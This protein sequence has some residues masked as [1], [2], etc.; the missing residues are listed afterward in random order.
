MRRRYQRA[1]SIP[2]H[3][4]PPIKHW[5]AFPS[6]KRSPSLGTRSSSPSDR[7]HMPPTRG[8]PSPKRQ[9]RS[10]VRSSRDGRRDRQAPRRVTVES[11][12]PVP[13]RSLERDPK[14]RRISPN[15]KPALSPSLHKSPSSSVSSPAAERSPSDKRVK[16]DTRENKDPVSDKHDKNK[17]SPQVQKRNSKNDGRRNY[18]ELSS[19]RARDSEKGYKAD[20]MNQEA[21]KL[22][23]EERHNQSHSLDSGSEESDHTRKHKRKDATPGDD[24]S[25]DSYAEDRKEAKRRR[26]EEKKLKK[27]EKRKRREERRRKKDIR[28]SEKLKLKTL[29]NVSPSSDLDKSHDSHDESTLSDQK[30]LEIELRE[31]ALESLRAKKGAGR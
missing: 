6:R 7:I 23:K 2:R 13:A 25:H 14:G 3:K 21:V 16:E 11:R 10:P 4:S 18:P 15:G 8:T 22:Q 31:K 30:K 29:G 20:E 5:A 19:D 9:Q 24:D 26:K 1:P 17:H 12:S 28:L 27:E